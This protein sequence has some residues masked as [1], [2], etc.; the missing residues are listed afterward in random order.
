V[1]VYFVHGELIGLLDGCGLLW[2]GMTSEPGRLIR[3]FS[4]YV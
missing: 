2:S 4:K 1:G 3:R